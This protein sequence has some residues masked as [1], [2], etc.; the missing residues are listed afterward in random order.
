MSDNILAGG[1]KFRIDPVGYVYREGQRLVIT[2]GEKYKKGLKYL[3]MFSHA[4]IIF[5]DDDRP[6]ILNTELSQK[7]VCLREVDEADGKITADRVEGLSDNGE[8]RT[9]YDIKPYF[10]NEDRVKDASVPSSD[11]AEYVNTLHKTPMEALGEIRRIRGNYYLE[12]YSESEKYM[13]VLKGYS[14]IKIFWWFHKFDKDM[15]RRALECDPPYENAPRTGVFASRSPVRP[16]PL[17]MTTARIIDVERE[18]GRIKVSCLDCYDHTPLLGIS[19]YVPETDCIREYRLPVWLE[20]WSGWLDDREFSAAKEPA[21]SESALSVLK[22]YRGPGQTSKKY[23]SE[24]FKNNS[25]QISGVTD[26]IVI[27]GARQHN[28]KNIDV[29]IPY[30]KITVITGVSGSGKSSLAFDTIYAESQQRFLASMSMAERSQFSLLEKPEFDQ[31]TGL[32][33]AI[34]ISQQSVSRNPRST[35]GTLTD[36]NTLLRVLYSAIGTRHCPECGQAVI[37]MTADEIISCLKGCRKGTVQRIRPYNMETDQIIL[38]V[39]GKGQ[40]ED[41]EYDKQYTGHDRQSEGYDERHTYDKQ[42]TGHDRQSEGYDERHA[43]DKQY[44]EYT[45]QLERAVREMLPAGRGAVQVQLDG[46]EDMTFQTTEKCYHCGHILF[47]MTPADFSFNNTESMCPVCNGLGS[48]MDVDP[49]L[50]VGNPEKPLLDGASAFWGDL[51]KFRKAPNANWMKGELLGLA[52]EMGI[53]LEIPWRELP[54]EFRMK[55]LYG[56][57]GKE[58][59]FTYEN[60]NGRTGTIKRPVEGAC[61]ILK[62]LSQSAGSDRQGAL[63]EAFMVSKPCECCRGERLKLESRLVTVADKRFPEVVKMSMEELKEWIDVLPQF[64]ESGEAAAARPILQELYVKLTDYIKTGLGYLNLD[65]QVPT[66]SGGEL[67]RLQLV[68]QLN[69]G[70]SNIL[71]ILDEPTAGLHP[72]DY[73]KLMEIIRKL[74]S[75]NNTVVIV[76]HSPAVMM[77]ADYIIDIGGGAGA[78]GGYLIAQGTPGEIINDAKSVTGQYL[79]GKKS[80][81]IGMKAEIEDIHEWVEIT[82]ASGN[83]LKNIDVRFPVRAITCITGVSGSGKSSLVDTCIVPAVRSCIEGTAGTGR[84]YR[85]VTGAGNFGRIVHVTQKPIGRSSRSTPATYTGIMDEIRLIF[86][87]TQDAVVRGYTQSRFSYNSKEG[88]CP[89][90]RGYGYKALEA[91]FMPSAKVECPLCRGRKFNSDTLQIRYRNKNIA[92]VLDMSVSEAMGF[93]KDNKKLL[94]ILELLSEIGLG[95]IRLGQSSQTLSGGEAQRIKLAAELSSNNA[96]NTLYLLDEPTT[97]LHF[98]DIQNLLDILQKIRENGNTV[99]LVEHNLDVVKNADWIIDLGPEGGTNGGNLVAQ[100]PAEDIIRCPESYT[101]KLLK[102]L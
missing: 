4:I 68:S 35:V 56:T 13:Q 29:T 78:A 25:S 47:E 82:G 46:Q 42:C 5:G 98:S 8:K 100:G 43:Y 34:A 33:P 102:K 45:R 2:V 90:C 60:K 81:Q 30:G 74:K 1:E 75:L 57:G 97:G 94:N 16:N 95:Y 21:P 96:G 63:A 38:T 99:I 19:P 14:H 54:E 9:L 55:A 77:A 50:I 17:A 58:V 3:S 37:K 101:G 65:R 39:P 7:V 69:S 22:R 85:G 12:L 67:Q 6:N 76:E 80:L 44:T 72:K 48:V 41:A 91:A 73:D 18:T 27:K 59:T 70:I 53:D 24:Y 92:D 36:I 26:G 84:E 88:Q 31:I 71:Y 86:A 10:P 40:G 62:R 49:G 28:L 66:L 93:F 87:R 11:A 32:P 52:D 64:L 51:R 83:N 61:N 15:Y 23:G 20:H 89:V 79:A